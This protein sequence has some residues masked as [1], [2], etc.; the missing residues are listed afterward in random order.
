MLGF[1]APT[2]ALYG[3]IALVAPVAPE[4]VERRYEGPAEAVWDAGET[5]EKVRDAEEP[6]VPEPATGDPPPTSASP[7][8]PTLEL[9]AVPASPYRKPKRHRVVYNN[10]FAVRYNPLGLVDELSAGYRLQLVRRPG[11]LYQDSYLALK[12][13]TFLNPAFGR[14]GPLLEFAPLT[15]LQFTVLYDYVGWFTTFDQLQSFPTPTVDYSDTALDEG[16]E[17]DRN[18]AAHGHL[19][20]LGMLLQAKIGR[21]AVRDNL[22]AYYAD[23]KLRDQDTVYY[24]QTLDILEPD[25]GWALTNDADLI[26]L[27]D[28]GLKI[29]ARHTLTHAFYQARHFLPGEP[30]S[31]PNSPTHRIGP[32]A[33]FTFYDRPDRRFNKPT[34]I[35]LAQWWV[36]HRWRTGVDTH[37]AIPYTALAFAFEGDLWPDPRKKS[38]K[39][40]SKTR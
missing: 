5:P 19:V 21:V 26:Y 36:R 32:A 24:D 11:A 15:V 25:E 6:E 31:R 7:A 12:L 34:L 35:L 27:F 16:G 2:V 37:A 10:L 3:S 14:V 23:L 18:Y 20:T 30:V 22:K 4:T 8:G 13:H 28:F 29:G 33:L 17:A 9:P 38:K 1:V 40:R 39:T